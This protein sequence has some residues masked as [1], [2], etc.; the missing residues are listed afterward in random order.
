MSE[1]VLARPSEPITASISRIF[2]EGEQVKVYFPERR[3]AWRAVV[4]RLG[5]VWRP[6]YW[7]KRVELADRDHRAAEV[8]RDLLAA[9]FCVKAHGHIVEM[10]A[11]GNFDPEPR[12]MVRAFN[13]AAGDYAGWFCLWWRRDEDCYHAAKRLPG[14][15]YVKPSIAVP[16]EQF[17][18]I[19][20]FASLYDF[21]WT[22][23][24]RAVAD[25]ARAEQEAALV[26]DV[27]APEPLSVPPG[28]IPVL[29]VPEAVDIDEDLLDAD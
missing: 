9:G 25:A 20:D 24:A 3:D 8:V 13:D 5:Y 22:A 16:P 11:S 21:H 19:E 15:R 12:R 1:K 29:A 23:A 10:A 18:A 28:R 17:A 27:S 14:A 2:L 7:T 6:P 4:K 26:L